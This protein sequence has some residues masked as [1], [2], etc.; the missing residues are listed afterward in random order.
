MDITI[1]KENTLA[2][3]KADIKAEVNE[4]LLECL[5]EKYGVAEMIRTGTEKSKSNLIGVIVGQ[6]TGEDGETNPIVVAVNAAVKEFT[7]HASDKKTYTP[8]DFYATAADYDSYITT[9]AAQAEAAAKTKAENI[10]KAEA[11]K[12]EVKA[13]AT[14]GNEDF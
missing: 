1:T 5:R 11:K 3:A 6:G 7:N 10:A 14:G 12:K 4:Y 9:K 2:K 13:Q 8:F